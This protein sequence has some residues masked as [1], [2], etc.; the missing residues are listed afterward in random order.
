MG[1]VAD[2]PAPATVSTA[3]RSTLTNHSC[4]WPRTMR[5]G[6][7]VKSAAPAR[8]QARQTPGLHDLSGRAR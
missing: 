6:P 3:P 4:R 7:A 1:A 2:S 8:G 5:R